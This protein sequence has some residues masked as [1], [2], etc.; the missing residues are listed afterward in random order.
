MTGIV[1]SQLDFEI[2]HPTCHSRKSQTDF[3]KTDNREAHSGDI[4][5]YILWGT[6]EQCS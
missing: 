6:V 5:S 3:Q 1:T 4:A 2:S